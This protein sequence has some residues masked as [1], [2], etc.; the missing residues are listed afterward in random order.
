MMLSEI[1][2]EIKNWFDKN[3]YYGTFTIVDGSLEQSEI[4]IQDG[5]YFRII[6]ST[7]NDGVYKYPA[8]DLHDEVFRGSVWALAIPKEVIDLSAEID[9]WDAKYGGVDSAAMSPFNSESFGGY[10]YSKS[11]GGASEG[12]SAADWRS[13]FASRLNKWR[14]I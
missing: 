12:V 3:R 7:F 14:K 1:C 9:A 2:R 4:E 6:G 8:T 5:Q 13:Q 10:S 11:G